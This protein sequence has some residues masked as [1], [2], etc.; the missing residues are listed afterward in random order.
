MNLIVNYFDKNIRVA[1]TKD[2]PLFSA[3]D[4]CQV[5]GIVNNRNVVAKLNPNQK[6][7]I[8]WT[9]IKGPQKC[10]FVTEC[11]LYKL[12]FKS[13]KPEA[14]KFTNYICEEVIP[15]I[16]K[17]GQYPP[18]PINKSD[19]KT[20]KLFSE[21]DL[22]KQVI[23]FIRTRCD[24][25]FNHVVSCGD[26]QDSSEK[27]IECFAKGYVSGTP[28]IVI[29]TPNGE[30]SGLILELKSPLGTGIVSDAQIESIERF[31]NDGYKTL[32][33]NDYDEILC[34]LISYKNKLVESR[35][36]EP[37]Q[38]YLCPY[39]NK[40]FTSPKYFKTHLKKHI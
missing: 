40:N 4:V 18:P 29:T 3:K 24:N 14:E 31:K 16:R 12:I 28:D 39:C 15:S 26:L 1:G 8:S 35:K 19:I 6:E 11:G 20:M 10:T 21:N 34:E 9:T 32:I 30:H 5:L 37:L 17:H 36:P 27:R 13:T 22:Q 2:K 25:V 33:S 7:S 38:K 23:K